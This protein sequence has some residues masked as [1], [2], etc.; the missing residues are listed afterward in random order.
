[1]EVRDD[2]CQQ[3]DASVGRLN[4]PVFACVSMCAREEDE[5]SRDAVFQ[6]LKYG[7]H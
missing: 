6:T 3:A 7:G 1:V 5:F 2:P 4:A